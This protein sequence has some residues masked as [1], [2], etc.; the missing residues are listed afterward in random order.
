MN[1]RE[2]NKNKELYELSYFFYKII[3]NIIIIIILLH[4]L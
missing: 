2:K 4:R 1:Y 3:M